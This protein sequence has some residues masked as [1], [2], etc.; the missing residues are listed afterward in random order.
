MHLQV[1]CFCNGSRHAT[2]TD[3]ASLRLLHG[4]R[5]RPTQGACSSLPLILE[6]RVLAAR[7]R[8]L[9][10]VCLHNASR[11]AAP[12]DRAS[13]R[14][15]R[16][17]RR[18][19][20][21]GACESLLVESGRGGGG[22]WGVTLI[23]LSKHFPNLACF[24]DQHSNPKLVTPRLQPATTRSGQAT[25]ALAQQIA[26]SLHCARLSQQPPL[27]DGLHAGPPSPQPA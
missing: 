3:R 2:P 11:H 27:R 6:C 12:T 9:Q 20:T 15:L 19:P 23:R 17:A 26:E 25:P 7:T 10:V 21:Q 16:G 18:R 5:P 14:L 13:L 22:G 8:H 1:R 24:M 4:A